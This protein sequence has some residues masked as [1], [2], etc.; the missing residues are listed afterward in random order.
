MPTKITTIFL[1]ELQ[2]NLRK[3][4]PIIEVDAHVNDDEF[5]YVAFEQLLEVMREK[6]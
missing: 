5:A 4:I 6:Q 2:R 1:E 3:D